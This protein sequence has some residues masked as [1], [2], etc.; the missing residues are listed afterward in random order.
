MHNICRDCYYYTPHFIFW[1]GQFLPL[2]EGHCWWRKGTL[3]PGACPACRRFAPALPYE[4]FLFLP[5]S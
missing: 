3:K 2:N 4:R 5:R 1:E